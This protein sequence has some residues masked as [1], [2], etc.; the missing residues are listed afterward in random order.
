MWRSS[1]ASVDQSAT[2]KWSWFSLE[3][4][5]SRWFDSF[6][7]VF[8]WMNIYFEPEVYRWPAYVMILA[9]IG[10]AFLTLAVI[11]SFIQQSRKSK[12]ELPDNAFNAKA[13]LKPLDHTAL[14]LIFLALSFGLVLISA[15]NYAVTFGDAG[16][17]GRYLFPM[18]SAFALGT[19][20]GLMWLPGLLRYALPPKWAVVAGGLAWVL[21]IGAG[22]GLGYLNLHA[23]NDRII[24]A[25]TVP[26]NLSLNALPSNATPIQ[27]GEFDPGM[28]LVGY[29]VE[30]PPAN[31]KPDQIAPVKL[32]LYWQ[33]QNSMKDNWVGFVHLYAAGQDIG[34]SDGTPGK[35]RYQTFRWKKGEIVKDERVIPV[36]AE[37]WNAA[38]A[39]NKPLRLQLGWYNG[40]KRATINNSGQV[41]FYFDW[42]R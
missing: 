9:G 4:I 25:Y 30:A 26:T 20:A 31:L 17:Q 6:W 21:V 35:G 19:A 32:T 36:K 33:A 42:N 11:W 28:W 18:L 12:E 8:G 14:S 29:E 5:W 13:G 41:D 15:L 38:V 7:G 1:F 10:L 16:T 24:P 2:F 23:L 3:H 27:G 34:Q 39:D 37:N 40:G 22:L